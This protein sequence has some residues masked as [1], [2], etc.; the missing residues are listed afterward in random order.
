MLFS[1]QMTCFSS[2]F[3]WSLGGKK[4]AANHRKIIVFSGLDLQPPGEAK[5]VF[6]GC[7]DWLWL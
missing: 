3:H 5:K 1:E 7:S 6:R 2:V 4:A